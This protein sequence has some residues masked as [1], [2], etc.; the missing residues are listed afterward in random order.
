MVPRIRKTADGNDRLRTKAGGPRIRC[1]N[2]PC[3]D[4]DCC[5][6]DFPAI[7]NCAV[8]FFGSC[9]D[10][11]DITLTWDAGEDAWLGSHTYND[12]GGDTTLYVAFGC[13]EG[14]SDE[15]DLFLQH[16][17]S[18]DCDDDNWHAGPGVGGHT[19]DPLDCEFAEGLDPAGCRSCSGNGINFV[20][21]EKA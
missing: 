5:D 10:D 8:D 4:T 16:R 14:G 12:G 3:V 19:C 17:T 15:T 11:V 13:A 20:V 18:D 6:N 21:T 2:C 1:A 7:L 9:T